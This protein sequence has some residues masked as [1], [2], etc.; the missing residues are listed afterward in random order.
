M[1]TSYHGYRLPWHW[2]FTLLWH[3]GGIFV[4]HSFKKMLTK[5]RSMKTAGC[6]TSRVCFIGR[7]YWNWNSIRRAQKK[8]P[9]KR[10]VSVNVSNITASWAEIR[11]YTK[12]SDAKKVKRKQS[13]ICFIFTT[14]RH[15]LAGKSFS[16]FYLQAECILSDFQPEICGQLWW[17][18]TIIIL[19][20]A[21]Y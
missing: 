4:L 18:W 11:L 5:K 3:L 12:P 13:L 21:Y 17:S 2:L 8:N 1:T 10:T 14:T 6:L 20:F 7:L 9:A 15:W 19:L 16:K